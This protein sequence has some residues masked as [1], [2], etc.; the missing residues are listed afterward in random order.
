M[1]GVRLLGRAAYRII[2]I[3]AGDFFC[4]SQHIYVRNRSCAN[5]TL[6]GGSGGMPPPPENIATVRLSLVGFGS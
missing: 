6:L 2:H 3:I 5:H 1:K 4:D